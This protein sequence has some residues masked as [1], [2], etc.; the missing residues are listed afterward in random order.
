MLTEADMA[1]LLGRTLTDAETDNFSV[2]LNIATERLEELLCVDLSTSED[3]ATRT[4]G[5]RS[6]YR[7]VYVDFFTE[8]TAVTYDG[9]AVDEDD[10]TIKQNDRFNGSWYNIIEF[11]SKRYGENITVTG[12]WGFGEAIPDDLAML[13]AQ[14]FNQV[15]VSQVTDGQ[16]KSKKIEDFMVTY[17]DSTTLQ[18]VVSSNSAVIDKYGQCN[19]GSIRHGRI[20]AFRYY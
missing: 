13:L 16:V 17:K 4:F 7:T 19:Q 8:V 15:S 11:D 12:T 18:E 5:T 9:E 14:L 6:G 1:I 20:F 2:Y 3:P 10:Y